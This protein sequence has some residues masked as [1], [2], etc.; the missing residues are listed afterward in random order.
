MPSAA[1]MTRSSGVVMK[2]RT[3][4]AFAPTYVVVTVISAFSLRGYC[5]ALRVRIAWTPAMTMTRLT[6]TAMTGRRMKRSVNFMVAPSS[7]LGRPRGEQRLGREGVV[8]GHRRAV[9]QLE[10]AARDDRLALAEPGGHRDEVPSAFAGP[11]EL[12]P[13]DGG[14]LAGAVLLLLDGEHRV[15][16]GREEDG[17]GGDGEHP[18]LLARE[19]LD[20]R[21]HPGSQA[22]VAIREGGPHAHVARRRI[23]LG[24]DGGD[25]AL[26]RAVGER[27]GPQARPLAGPDVGERLLG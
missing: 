21:E 7:V 9:P 12:L 14:R 25:V 20:V 3:S 27:V 4:S 5:R 16:V 1:A 11:D 6:T 23:H 24:V 22:S 2:P 19:D 13:H 18:L 17:R 26:P 10:G 15:P 8:H